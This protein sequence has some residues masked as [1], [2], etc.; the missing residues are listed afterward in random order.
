[1][2]HRG[3][4]N[5]SEWRWI[6]RNN[7]ADETKIVDQMISWSTEINWLQE[8]LRFSFRGGLDQK[9]VKGMP[10]SSYDKTYHVTIA[11]FRI[12]FSVPEY[13]RPASSDFGGQY[14]F[15]ETDFFKWKNELSDGRFQGVPTTTVI[16]ISYRGRR[17]LIVPEI[18]KPAF[19]T[20]SEA[21]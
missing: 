15:D 14:L 13:V 5:R 3:C 16:I 17:I 6:E 18:P 8:K 11:N 1:M 10:F 7:G 19:S 4:L 9:T 20:C 2:T 21:V 12:T